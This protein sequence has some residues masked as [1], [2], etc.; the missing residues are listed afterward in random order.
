MKNYL[1]DVLLECA[2]LLNSLIATVP[3]SFSN[4]KL[5]PIAE[6]SVVIDRQGDTTVFS[7]NFGMVVTVSEATGEYKVNTTQPEF[8]TLLTPCNID[9]VY[10]EWDHY[11]WLDTN[12]MEVS[13]ELYTIVYA[14]FAV[15]MYVDRQEMG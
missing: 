13:R 4:I 12:R 5:V 11:D 7:T 6:P 3:S 15:L 10:Q 2:G 14:F 8:F 9:G 1:P